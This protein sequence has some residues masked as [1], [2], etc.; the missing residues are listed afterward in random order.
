[1]AQVV[2]KSPTLDLTS[3][4][5][6]GVMSLSPTLGSMLAMEATYKKIIINLISK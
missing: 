5:A 1:M 4:L 3:G 6:L 2:V